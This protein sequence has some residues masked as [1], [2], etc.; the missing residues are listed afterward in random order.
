MANCGDD[1]TC[2]SRTRALTCRYEV[3]ACYVDE[4]HQFRHA[5]KRTSYM[6]RL[7]HM[8]GPHEKAPFVLSITATPGHHPGEWG[9]LSSLYAQVHGDSPAAWTD[10]GRALSERGVP[11][12]TS[13]GKWTWTAEAKESLPTQQAAISDCLLYTS[14]AADE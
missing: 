8:D 3:W 9:Y 5:S 2:V 14:D 12:E 13:Y 1:H 11:L 7:T 4:A 10:F 6:R